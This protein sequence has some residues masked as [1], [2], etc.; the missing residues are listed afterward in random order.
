MACDFYD[1]VLEG[2]SDDIGASSAAA[3]EHGLSQGT[4]TTQTPSLPLV[5][6]LRHDERRRFDEQRA[7]RR[8][9]RRR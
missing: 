3:S 2:F 7:E 8:R 9:R 1:F 6:I 5:C 4:A